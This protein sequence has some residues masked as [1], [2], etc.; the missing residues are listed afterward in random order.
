M[1]AWA[2]TIAFPHT[3]KS[4]LPLNRTSSTLSARPV[5]GHRDEISVNQLPSL[6][7]LMPCAS[8]PGS[9]LMLPADFGLPADLGSGEG[10]PR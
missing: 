1:H 8:E 3:W 7:A 6:A 2:A 10:R 4:D 9:S 5:P